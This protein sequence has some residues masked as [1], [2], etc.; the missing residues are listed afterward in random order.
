MLYVKVFT[1][2]KYTQVPYTTD[3]NSLVLNNLFKKVYRLHD[4]IFIFM[5]KPVTTVFLNPF[6]NA[7]HQ[8]Y[9][10]KIAIN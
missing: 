5:Y 2:L 9:S 10:E 4:H 8:Q 1:G 3:P 6:F 7:D